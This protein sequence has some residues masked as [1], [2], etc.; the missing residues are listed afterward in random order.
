ME[1]LHQGSNLLRQ[2]QTPITRIRAST[3]LQGASTPSSSCTRG[4]WKGAP[5]AQ[6]RKICA[7]VHE[8][9]HWQS[10]VSRGVVQHG[11]QLCS[12]SLGTVQVIT[13]RTGRSIPIQFK[14][15]PGELILTWARLVSACAPRIALVRLSHPP[16]ERESQSEPPRPA[17]DGR[18]HRFRGPAADRLRLGRRR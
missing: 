9:W 16:P 13:W 8:A 7:G 17:S 5:Y 18:A 11:R 14:S 1:I 10:G 15:W 6:L 4:Y 3:R 12:R 2:F